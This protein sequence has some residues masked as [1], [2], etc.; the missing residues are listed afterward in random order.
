MKK[1]TFVSVISLLFYTSVSFGQ[2]NPLHYGVKLGIANS[3]MAKNFQNTENSRIGFTGGVFASYDLKK[4]FSASLEIL[5][6]QQGV[7]NTLPLTTKDYPTSTNIC[8]NTIE[9]PLLFIYN[10]RDMEGITPR[11]FAG[12]S[13]G[14]II[15]AIAT[16]REQFDVAPVKYFFTKEDVTSKFNNLDFGVIVGMGIG[17][18]AGSHNLIF[19]VRYKF[20]YTNINTSAFDKYSNNA[21]TITAGLEL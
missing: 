2:D 4:A 7:T 13:F 9:A 16:N 19:D 15:N 21:L 12:H 10:P 6:L 5:Y 14:Y 8:F 11:F 17:F 20:G 1:L 3:N 18:K